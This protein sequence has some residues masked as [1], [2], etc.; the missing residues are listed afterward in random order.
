MVADTALMPDIIIADSPMSED[1]AGTDSINT[2]ALEKKSK[3]GAVGRRNGS[4]E[5]GNLHQ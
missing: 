1:A 5:Q 4:R 2:F 3:E